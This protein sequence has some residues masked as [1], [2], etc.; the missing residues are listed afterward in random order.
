MAPL[1][2]A[3]GALKFPMAHGRWAPNPSNPPMYTRTRN[4]ST[5][6]CIPTASASLRIHSEDRSV[7]HPQPTAAASRYLLMASDAFQ[8]S[9]YAPVRYG[10][11]ARS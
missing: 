11:L 5:G 10:L 4:S 1:L 2:L 9:G 6:S 8:A 3:C 7:W